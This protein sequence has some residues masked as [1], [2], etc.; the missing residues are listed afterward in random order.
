MVK[1]VEQSQPYPHVY[2]PGGLR[3]LAKRSLNEL[4]VYLSPGCDGY[5]ASYR[6]WHRYSIREE[7]SPQ[8]IFVAD[9]YLLPFDVGLSVLSKVPAAFEP[10]W[11][12]REIMSEV[13]DHVAEQ[14]WKYTGP[15]PQRGVTT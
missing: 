8:G 4:T 5:W 12:V 11:S 13:P 15:R 1:I 10:R 2:C 9:N 7:M 3:D 14:L 6:G